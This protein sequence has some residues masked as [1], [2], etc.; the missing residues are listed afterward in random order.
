MDE[1]E[2]VKQTLIDQKKLVVT[3]FAGF[4]EGNQIWD[5]GGISLM[6]SMGEF[7]EVAL[8]DMGHNV[9]YIIPNIELD[10]T[11]SYQAYSIDPKSEPVAIISRALASMD[12]EPILESTGG[13]SDANVFIEKGISAIPVGIGVR[14][15][16]TTWETAQIAEVMLGAQMCEGIIKE[17]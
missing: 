14:D 17:V 4:D 2:Q 1:M 10:I 3:Y 16:H 6:F 11:N 9:K 15:F 13:G 8:K 7:Q 5:S 12:L